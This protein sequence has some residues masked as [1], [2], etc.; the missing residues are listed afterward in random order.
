MN[1]EV[2]RM[3]F[4]PIG[5][6]RS[7]LSTPGTPPLQSTFS[8]VVGTIEIFPEYQDGL[9]GIE[10]FSHLIILSYFH[11]AANRALTERPLIDGEDPHGIFTTRHFNRPNPIGISYV[12]L[13]NATRGTLDVR[14]IDLLDGTPVLDIKPYIPAFDSIPVAATGW[15]TAEHID[16]IR[17]TSIHAGSGSGTDRSS[18]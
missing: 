15:V 10:K 18:H 4:V 1:R 6:V 17:V 12:E 3:F 16:R 14:G 7:P 11:C 13:V 8:Q 5:I 9:L 2:A